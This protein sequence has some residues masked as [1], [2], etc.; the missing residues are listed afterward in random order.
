[1]KWRGNNYIQ[2]IHKVIAALQFSKAFYRMCTCIV[3]TVVKLC[4]ICRFPFKIHFSETLIIS[5]FIT[6]AKAKA[7]GD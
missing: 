6:K 4:C 2:L 5:L 1:V 7:L 3:T